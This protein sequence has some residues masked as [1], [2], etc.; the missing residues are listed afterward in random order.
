VVDND[1]QTQNLIVLQR[2]LWRDLLVKTT[3]MVLTARPAV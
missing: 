2:R 3:L 1:H